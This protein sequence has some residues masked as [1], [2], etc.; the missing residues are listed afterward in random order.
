MQRFQTGD[1]LYEYWNEGHYIFLADNNLSRSVSEGNV[2]RDY[3]IGF[4][5]VIQ[6]YM[7]DSLC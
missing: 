7:T 5:N 1:S 3:K 6:T 2:L 4:Q